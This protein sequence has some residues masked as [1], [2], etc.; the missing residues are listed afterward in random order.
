MDEYQ[1]MFR[2]LAWIFYHENI[3]KKTKM[4]HEKKLKLL[5]FA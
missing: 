3:N 4:L 5:L 2:L 1:K